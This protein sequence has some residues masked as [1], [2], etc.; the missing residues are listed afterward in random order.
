MVGYG[1]VILDHIMSLMN[2]LREKELLQKLE[3]PIYWEC[4]YVAC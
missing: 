3:W 4:L 2:S 1:K